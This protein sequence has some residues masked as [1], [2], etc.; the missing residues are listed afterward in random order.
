MKYN[1]LKKKKVLI[2]GVSGFVGQH[3]E[4]KLLEVGALVYGIS[5]DTKKK[6]HIAG[7]VRD[8]HFLENIIENKKIDICF[9]LAG[10]ALV[11]TGQMNPYQTFQANLL[12]TLNILEI[13]RQYGLE[14][15]IIASTSH[16]YGDNKVPYYE[17]YSPRPSRPYETS[18]TCTDLLA[19]SYADT[20]SLPVLIPRFVNIYGPGDRNFSRLIPK[21]IQTILA[22][23]SPAM[24][25]GDVIRQYLYIDDAVKA[26]LDLATA[27]IFTVGKNRICNFGSPDKISVKSLIQLLIKLSGASLSIERVADGREAEI[28]EQYVSWYKAKKLLHWSPKVPLEKGLVKTIAWYKENTG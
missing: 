2:T 17:K 6:T 16:V 22:G 14:K 24:W 19:Q 10:E 4:K 1:R 25:G 23:K 9:H 26:Y 28:K 15:I 8:Y 18:K 11:E 5:R 21:T 20:F 27:D 13:S 7:D 12:G 3:L